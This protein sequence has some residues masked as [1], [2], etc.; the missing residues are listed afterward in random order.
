MTGAGRV[1]A[2]GA[3]KTERGP[4]GR[5]REA[6]PNDFVGSIGVGLPSH[7]PTLLLCVIHAVPPSASNPPR[8]SP[9]LP[10]IPGDKQGGKG[11]G[12]QLVVVVGQG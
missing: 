8:A 5:V 11:G 10:T 12:G 1:H 3:G 6:A 2:P 4:R 7:S 9:A